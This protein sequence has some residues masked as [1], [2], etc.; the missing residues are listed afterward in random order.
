VAAGAL[1][2]AGNAATLAPKRVLTT[3]ASAFTINPY[4]GQLSRR[5]PGAVNAGALTIT[6]QGATLL[7]KRVLSAQAGAIQFAGASVVEHDIPGTAMVW[8]RQ[9]VIQQTFWEARMNAD[10]EWLAPR[11]NAR[12]VP[13]HAEADWVHPAVVT[14]WSPTTISE[15]KWKH[16]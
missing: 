7:Y 12:M 4:F 10:A 15:A 2:L 3:Q 9:A 6:G 8:W 13:T 14:S 5:A 11:V 1:A 16:G